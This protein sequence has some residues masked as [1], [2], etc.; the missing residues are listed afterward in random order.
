MRCDGLS[1][2]RR[3]TRAQCS[4]GDVIVEGEYRDGGFADGKRGGGHDG[5][6]EAFEAL[7]GV[8]KFGRN[9]WGASMN[10]RPDMVR[11]KT[12]DPFAVRR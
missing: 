12:D 10:L 3:L 11:H 5:R 1:H 6:Q 4:G 8:R 7:A 2:E 9:T